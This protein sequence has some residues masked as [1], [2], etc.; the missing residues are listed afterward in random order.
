MNTIFWDVDTQVDFIEP[1]GNLAVDG[2]PQIKDN[3]QKLLKFA[4]SNDFP[5]FGSVDYHDPDDEELTDEPDFKNTFPPHCVAGEK[6]QQKIE[7]TKPKN[8]LWIDSKP[9]KKQ[10]LKEKLLEH[11][12][13][14]YFR[15][16]KFDVFTNP[17]VEP[18]MK[19][20][21][22]EHIII[23]GVTLD[24][25][26]RFAVEGFFDR[27]YKVSVIKDATKPIDP[28]KGE[29]LLD[30]WINRGINIVS[31]RGIIENLA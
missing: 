4:R 15:K 20:V 24:V 5:V 16:Q 22:P 31:T 1:D 19:I 18:G 25:C 13:E 27:G 21:Q 2:A 11:D 9:L 7:E 17:N 26:V 3:L 10:K 12:S 29:S 8:P 23:F 14:I 30:S 6:G 28:E